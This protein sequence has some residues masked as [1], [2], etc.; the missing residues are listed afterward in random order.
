[1]PNS[2][3]SRRRSSAYTPPPL[4]FHLLELNLISAQDLHRAGARTRAFAVAWAHPDHKLRTR[5]D[6]SGNTDPVWNE[7]FVFRVDSAFL[8]SETS[9]ITVEIYAARRGGSRLL[10]TVRVVISTFRPSAA[11]ASIAALQVRRPSSLRPQGILNVGLSLLD[12]H[13]RSMPLFA[14]DL[15]GAAAHSFGGKGIP[16]PPSTKVEDM[17]METKLEKWKIE[18]S[19]EHGGEQRADG[20]R[21]RR[22]EGNRAKRRGMLSCYGC[23]HGAADTSDSC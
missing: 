13:V 12:S 10:G 5:P 17:E 8:Q 6:L 9:G 3:R 15:G 20:H 1:M 19:P 14:A 4:P 2:G 18:M 7:R 11:S 21:S 23:G 16:V 22:G